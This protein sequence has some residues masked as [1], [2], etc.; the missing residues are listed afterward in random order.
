MFGEANKQAYSVLDYLTSLFKKKMRS[1]IN[2]SHYSLRPI[3]DDLFD[4][5]HSFFLDAILISF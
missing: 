1:V 2:F 3:L 5:V 4:N